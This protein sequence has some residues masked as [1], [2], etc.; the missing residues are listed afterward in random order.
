MSIFR[1]T[2]PQLKSSDSEVDRMTSP[3]EISSSQTGSVQASFD[4]GSDPGDRVF[5]TVPDQPVD[6]WLS[7]DQLI[8]TAAPRLPQDPVP[9]PVANSLA[10]A[11]RTTRLL[12]IA[13]LTSLL[14]HLFIPPYIIT[15][16]SRPEKVALID[17]TESLIITSLV[18][19]EESRELLETISYWAA[20]SFL[21]RGPQG[22]DAP[23]TLERVFLPQALSKAKDEFKGMADE[24]AKK[25][26]HQKLEIARIDLQSLG[27]GSVMSHVT[28]QILSQAQIG[29][30]HVD[31]PIPVTLDLKLARNPYLGRN[32]RYPYAVADYT[33]GT[34]PSL[35]ISKHDEK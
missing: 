31:E 18:S 12:W 23:D 15:T 35:S 11:N 9:N 26:I 13:L 20:K 17:G 29:D 27:D 24:Y 19:P 6:E 10:K 28:G 33:F 1:N 25:N 3:Q 14:A 8:Q 32:K 30:R 16:M 5:P 21:E 22:F 4:H 2:Q 7:H 34:P